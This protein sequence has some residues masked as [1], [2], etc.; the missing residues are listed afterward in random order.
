[1]AQSNIDLAHS[2]NR[3]SSAGKKVRNS[4]VH[5]WI[6]SCLVLW[7]ALAPASAELVAE[8]ITQENFDVRSVGG[9]DSDAGVGDW[10]L[11][12]GTLC[13]A[14][15]DPSHESALTPQGGVLIDLGHCGGSNDQ[16]TV[17]QP[18]LNLSQ[19]HVVPVTEI[20]ADTNAMSAWIRTRAV[21][22]GIEILTTYSVDETTP[23][24]LM[25]SVRARRVS[26]GDPLFSIGSVVLHPTG[27]TPPFSLLRRALERS[28]GFEYPAS[29]RRSAVSL[30]NSLISSDLTVLVGGDEMPPV[31]YGVEHLSTTLREAD[32]LD[33]LPTFSVTGLHFTSLNSM[34]R[35]FWFGENDD[36][37]GLLQLIQ[38]PFM[39][40]EPEAEFSSDSRIWIGARADVAS[41]TD[42]IW[43]EAPL[44]RGSINDANA[45]L[46]INLVSGAPVT[47]I[48]P[49]AGGSFEFRLPV[50]RYLARI[51]APS[52]RTASFEFEV[53]AEE[54][55]QS[56][57]S[58]VIGAPGSI[59]LPERFIGRLIF[60]N[61]NGSGPAS[62][63]DDLLGFKI[64]DY[65][66]PS[67][68]EAPFVNL[69]DSPLDP[70][71]VSLAP[72]QYRVVAV[73]G[74]EYEAVES[75]IEIRAGEE[76]RLELEPL[77]RVAPTPGWIA[78]DLHVH[79]GESFDSSLPQPRQIVAFA[80][81]G[82]E[83]LVA[84]EH[85]R[86]FDPRPAIARSGLT[87]QLVSITGVEVTSAFEGGD[88]PFTSGHLNAFPL[89]PIPGGYR[90]GAP[91]LEGR[92]LRDAL[93]DIKKLDP[94]PF[95]QLNHPRP[96]PG[97]GADDTYLSH[98]GD[99][100]DPF[101]PTLSLTEQPNAVLVEKSPEHAGRD[102]DFNGVELLNG[103]NL[104]RYRRVRADW[105]SLLLQGERIVGTANSDSHRLGVVVGLPRNYVQVANA[106]LDA[107]DE[108]IFMRSLGK[109]HVYGSTGP[110][111]TAR[112]GE[113]GLGELHKGSSGI[114]HVKVDAAPWVPVAEWR[115][116]VNGELVHRAPISA[117]GEASLP[118]AFAADAFVTVE[119]EGPAEG[120][121]RD[122]LPGFIPFA[123]TNPIFVDT[124]G[125]GRFDAPGLPDEIPRTLSDPD[126]PD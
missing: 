22:A 105:F 23:T 9:P 41:I 101:D 16:W 51:V 87:S 74:P 73:R 54:R 76:T 5:V 12:N 95:V 48:R 63:G 19:S 30:L 99:L 86:V 39:D 121:Y 49:N 40:V 123:F 65:E 71:R 109:G 6:A 29:D 38:I 96:G 124:D 83:V 98:I 32:Q 10:F 27:Q 55:T 108:G 45:R 43:T 120:L 75:L 94:A 11:G 68:L 28:H 36:T 44:I 118:L 114:L 13:A 53:N 14:I 17:L 47:E 80:A 50:G 81:S 31:S 37:P 34:T 62:F 1:L 60:L 102:L 78:A 84:A 92:R 110:F 4:L 70:K 24:A 77:A 42:Q 91:T 8:R 122:A 67:G 18:M 100:G 116:Y 61:A 125:N 52:D 104:V 103:E 15:S 20:T 97:E 69:A 82:A 33:P 59:R 58:I 115:A 46:H 85:D 25:I 64:G 113:A 56:L 88:S 72:G 107:F 79:S 57:P 66:A 7:G 21:F 3:F 90:G 111:V 26:E 112:L 126:L 117:G 35:P 119:I 89:K 2:R 93:A 106:D